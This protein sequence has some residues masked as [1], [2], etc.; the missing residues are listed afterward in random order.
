MAVRVVTVQRQNSSNRVKLLI[1]K[2]HRSGIESGFFGSLG[3]DLSSLLGRF[4]FHL[5]IFV[6]SGHL[7]A[8][9]VL[10]EEVKLALLYTVMNDAKEKRAFC[11]IMA[12]LERQQ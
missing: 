9:D 10:L 6:C 12:I 4:F 2:T 8:I 3:F 7:A 5:W 11:F 1:F